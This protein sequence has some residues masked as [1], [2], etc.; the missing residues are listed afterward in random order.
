MNGTN[1]EAQ[2][3]RKN[4]AAFQV[5]VVYFFLAILLAL[6]GLLTYWLLWPNDVLTI[7]KLPVPVTKPEDIKAG[8]LLVLKFDYCKF[9]AAEGTV[10]P[11]LVSDRNVVLLPTYE[12][13]TP[14]GCG[15]VDVPLILPYTIV[16]QKYHI[17]YKITYKV[18]PLRELTEEFDS[19]EFILN[20]LPI[21]EL[22]K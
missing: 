17:H 2:Q 7:N 16:E 10:E 18:N 6:L 14:T 8:R 22:P 9:N 4:E 1:L 3:V 21:S 20:P 11:S 19:A 5:K 15:K 12:D 13:K